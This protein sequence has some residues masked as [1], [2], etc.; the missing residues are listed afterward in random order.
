VP[1]DPSS[2]EWPRVQVANRIRQ[3][4]QAGQLGPKLP[5]HM[6]LA[7]QMGVAPMTV[8]KALA[9]LREEG[10]VYSVAGRGTFVTPA[11]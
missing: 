9:I 10:L 1:I 8:Q 11:G 3:Q 5:S 2:P 4:I 7:Q 6:E